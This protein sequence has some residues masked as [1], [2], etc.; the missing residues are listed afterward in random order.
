M[1]FKYAG[2]D[3]LGK[4]VYGNIE[5]DTIAI[6]K[7]KIKSKKIIYTSLIKTKLSLIQKLFQKKKTKVS[8]L[9][10]ATISRD[11]SIYLKS[12]ISLLN[13]IKLINERYKKDKILSAFFESIITFLDEGKNLYTALELQKII[14][15]PEFYLQSIKISEDG[16]ILQGVLL[17]LSIY[18]KEQ[19]RL[20]KQISQ[21]MAYPTVI[22][23]IA[24]LMVGFMLSFI[25]PT[26][27]EIFDKNGQDLPGITTFVINAGDFVNKYYQW[28]FISFFV[29]IVSFSYSMKNFSLFKYKVD[30]LYLKIPFIGSLLE[31][32]ELSRFSYM[33]SILIRSGVPVVQS[34]KMGA[35]IINNAVIKKLFEEASLKVVEGEKLSNILDK[36]KIYKVD[37]AFIQAIAIGEETSQLSEVLNNLAEFYTEANKDKIAKSLSLLEPL[38]MLFVGGSIGFIMIAMLLPIFSMSV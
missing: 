12:G 24:I 21:A 34:F 9:V 17:E 31:L 25:V 28:I 6:A 16:G 4:K 15:L 14:E 18:L 7:A 36:S 32:G 23:V 22:I 13:A 10:L 19:Y 27:T 37:V 8:T 3:K 11:L 1:L 20:Q 30:S 35:N 5:A 38:L 33:N 26:I 29:Y 2:Y